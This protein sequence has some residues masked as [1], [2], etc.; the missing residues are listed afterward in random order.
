MII[1]SKIG[2][3]IQ[4][5]KN[6]FL[7]PDVKLESIDPQWMAL[8]T[9]VKTHILQSRKVTSIYIRGSIP[10]G[11]AQSGFSDADFLCISEE[12]LDE[13]ESDINDQCRVKFPFVRGIEL[14][15]INQQEL[16]SVKP[17]RTRPYLE[18]LLKTQ[19]LFLEGVDVCKD[20]RPFRPDIEM[21]SHV[22]NLVKEFER[23]DLNSVEDRKWMSRRIVRSGL[24]ITLNRSQKFTRDLYFCFEEFTRYYPD[25]KQIMYT[26]LE[27]A[28]N[29]HIDIKN[30]RELIY[31]LNDESRHLLA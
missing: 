9:F 10:R 14:G 5:D 3:F 18:M 17:N 28:L 8:V 23:E 31:F 4:K 7:V 11:L 24:E 16:K 1:P 26:A 22:F 21:V 13:M 29:G 20:I 30:F 2:R 6:G 27:N 25:K 15:S 19:S 12:N